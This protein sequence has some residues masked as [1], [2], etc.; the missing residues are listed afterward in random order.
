MKI[1]LPEYD[2]SAIGGGWSFIA[3]FKKA[4]GDM[5]SGYDESDIFFIPSAS[6]T[7][8]DEVERAKRDGKKI[9]LRCDNIIRN[10]RNRNTGMSRMKAFSDAADTVVFQSFFA[11]DL[12]N[13]YLAAENNEVVYNAVDQS[14]FNTNGRVETDGKR[15][16]YAKHSSDE[17]KN[18]EM[19][20]VAFQIISAEFMDAHLNLVG[21]FDANVEQYNFDFYN[22]EHY[23]YWGYIT[24]PAAM[25]AIYKQ[26][27]MFIYTYFNDACS[28]TVIEALCCGVNIFDPYLM[29]ETGGTSEIL[30]MWQDHGGA[31]YFTLDRMRNDYLEVFNGILV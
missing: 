6:M 17:T 11:E 12:L 13:P 14:I 7:S 27:D 28:N 31:E 16:L 3:N 23:K 30:H 20:R 24:D 22:N 1:S 25:A 26:S 5:V 18:W 21:R 10:S 9:V 8:H 19:A 2:Q 29:G 15:Y 4:M